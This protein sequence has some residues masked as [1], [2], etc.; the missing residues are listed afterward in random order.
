MAGSSALMLA[1]GS[2]LRSAWRIGSR[3]AWWFSLTERPLSER[4]LPRGISSGGFLS[5]RH[6]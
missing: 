6:A 1:A 2:P 4:F 5:L 3:S